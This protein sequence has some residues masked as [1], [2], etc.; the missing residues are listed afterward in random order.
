MHLVFD[1]FGIFLSKK[2]EILEI[3]KAKKVIEKIPFFKITSILIANRGISFSSDFLFECYKNSISVTFNDNTGDS[4]AKLLYP[5]Q[6][7][8]A[9]NKYNQLRSYEKKSGFIFSKL[10][11][12]S[13]IKSQIF[14]V[15]YY[16]KKSKNIETKEKLYEN[17][18]LMKEQ[19]E[20]L[21]DLESR[22]IEKIREK[23]MSIEAVCAKYYWK[24]FKEMVSK[25]YQFD[26]RE[27]RYAKDIV[28][29]CLN[30]GYGI[31][32][33]MLLNLAFLNN[34]EPYFGFLHSNRYGKFSFILDIIEPFRAILVDSRVI[35]LLNKNREI[36]I[37]NDFIEEKIREKIV[38]L[39]KKQD[40]QV[41]LFNKRKMK[42]S[43]V[44]K[45]FFNEISK[46]FKEEDIKYSCFEFERLI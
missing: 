45:S 12:L 44:F 13:K 21:E 30:Y 23:I 27:K 46:I 34:F 16:K 39:V 17:I 22:S 14:M 29:Q 6:I 41:F 42:L 11:I 35:V 19:Y 25:S 1:E 3:K 38:K 18:K 43:F 26:K 9:Y 4:Y 2:S 10:M 20:I 37:E 7:L 40:E 24:S 5:N 15:S 8:N 31:L 28:N 33:S 36:K 32:Y